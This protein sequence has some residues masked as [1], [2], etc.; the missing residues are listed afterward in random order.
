M[1]TRPLAP[2]PTH[3][4]AGT[5]MGTEQSAP[6]ECR[7]NRLHP[8]R[9]WEQNGMR[10]HTMEHEKSEERKKVLAP[11]GAEYI[12][13]YIHRPSPIVHRPPKSDV[14]VVERQRLQKG[15]ERRGKNGNGNGN[16][17]VHKRKKERCWPRP[18][19]MLNKH[20]S[21]VSYTVTSTSTRIG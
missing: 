9:E 5:G 14:K 6:S 11:V 8:S 19:A 16:R 17:H 12:V 20:S 15:E 3:S 10:A 1:H 7:G 21:V 18:E 2:T 4:I 13:L